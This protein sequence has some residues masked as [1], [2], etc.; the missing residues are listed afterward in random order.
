[1]LLDGRPGMRRHEPGISLRTA[2]PGR[3]TIPTE[4]TG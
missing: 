1:V 4:R 2:D 3:P